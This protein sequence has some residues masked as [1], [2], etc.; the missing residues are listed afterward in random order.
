M[1]RTPAAGRLRMIPGIAWSRP[2]AGT[3]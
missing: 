3:T 2:A 1:A